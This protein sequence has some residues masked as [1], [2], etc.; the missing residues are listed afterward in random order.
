MADV[1]QIL[2]DAPGFGAVLA[3][4][5][6]Q[7]PIRIDPFPYL[8]IRD[9]LPEPVYAAALAHWPPGSAFA[10]TNYALRRQLNLSKDS[11]EMAPATRAFWDGILT[12]SEAINRALL[13]RFNAQ[14][15]LKFEPLL[16]AGWRALLQE[17]YTVSF[18]ETQLAQY[19]GRSWL[20]PHVDSPRVVTNSFLY[21]SDG[22]DI[23]PELGTVLYRAFG[24][25]L[26]DNNLKLSA[27]VQ[28]RVL[29]RDVVVP[30]QRN[31]LLAFVNT[32]SAFHGVDEFDIGDG[33]RRIML[34]S[35]L[36]RQ[37]EA[38]LLAD[39]HE[40]PARLDSGDEP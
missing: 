36:L 1:E 6:A 26:S 23:Q 3:Q 35:S 5:I 19:S 21:L 24:V 22:D 32:P 34:F 20:H 4:K 40:R 18:R 31:C 37:S 39:F 28:E 33:L 13:K 25:A 17:K 29:A 2:A 15:R 12:V 16:G 9:F 10:P 27:G 7:A 8:V 30:Y 11:I 14:L 38:N